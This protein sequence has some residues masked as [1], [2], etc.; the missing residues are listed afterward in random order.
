MINKTKQSQVDSLKQYIESNS[1]YNKLVIFGK[2]ITEDAK[3][4]DFLDIAVQTVNDADAN[5]N[6]ELLDLYCAVD[7]ITDGRFNLTIINCEYNS[8]NIMN[9]INKGEIIYEQLSQS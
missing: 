1:K 9:E 5:D 2:C 4:T 3:D 8:I 7:D 6:D